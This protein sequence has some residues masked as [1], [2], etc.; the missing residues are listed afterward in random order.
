M[1]DWVCIRQ[2]VSVCKE[3][4]NMMSLWK[5]IRTGQYKVICEWCPESFISEKVEG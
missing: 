4:G 3:C 2:N 5:N 1:T